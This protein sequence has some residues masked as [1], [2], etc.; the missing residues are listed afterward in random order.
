MRFR[1]SLAAVVAI[2]F[3]GLLTGCNKKAG[4]SGEFLKTKTGLEY[5]LFRKGADGAW[6]PLAL[7]DV[8]KVDTAKQLRAGKVMLLD[9]IA[10]NGKDSVLMNTADIGM[11]QPYMPN[12]A[13]PKNL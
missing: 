12:P 7:A 11:P 13:A 8:N 3:A 1:T 10:L 2:S 5:K 4:D 9:Q 6:A